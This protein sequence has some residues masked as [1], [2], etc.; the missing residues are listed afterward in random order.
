MIDLLLKGGKIYLGG[1]LRDLCLGI[2][3]GVIAAIGMEPVMPDA[4]DVIDI[5]GRIVIPG[6]VDPHVHIFSPGWIRETFE[7]GTAAAAVGG[8]TT[9]ADMASVGEWHTA[10]MEV[11]ERKLETASREALVDF[12]LYCGEI[13]REEDL[14]EIPQILKAGAVGLGEVMMCE[15]DPI[16]DSPTLLRAM[17]L[18]AEEDAVISVHAE[19]REIISRAI[20]EAKSAGKNRME[21]FS[22]SRPA[23]AEA[24]AI[25]DAAVLAAEAGSRLHVCH[26]STEAGVRALSLAKGIHELTTAEVTPHHLVL[27][28]DDYERL[29]PLIIVTPPVRTKG[30][31]ASLW[32][33]LSSGL[34]DAVATDHC[35]FKE[36]EKSVDSPWEVPAGLPGLETAVIL[37]WSE[38]VVKGRISLRRF[39][40]ATSEM[41]AKILGID[42]RKGGISIGKDADLTVIDP[43]YRG[44]IGRG[45]MRSVADY[46]PFDGLEVSGRIVMTMVR[47]RVVAREGSL[48]VK[49]GYGEFVP[50]GRGKSLGP[51][52]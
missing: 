39:V 41:P 23:V 43:S 14:R 35:A 49:P 27:T 46:T 12:A 37:L 45:D 6:A 2:D 1:E 4:D 34:I 42:H 24:K 9:V 28:L 15:P 48:E 16:P 17:R 19:D 51:G 30:D 31:V 36:A 50:R 44:R 38:G 29:G 33:A 52:D 10:T 5:S 26:V 11:F 47:G 3:G 22:L 40:E 13:H 32:E 25:L 18:V 21:D 20:S 8:V 7:T